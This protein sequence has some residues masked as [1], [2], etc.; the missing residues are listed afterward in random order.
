IMVLNM[1]GVSILADYFVIMHGNSERQVGAIADGILDAAEK[2]NIP[3]KRIEGQKGGDWLLIDL[4]D[5]IVHVFQHETRN[6]YNLEKLW[7]DAEDVAV[8]Q[9][10]TE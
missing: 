4:N 9:W 10:V 1:Q 3:V 6:F 5:V 8:S 2:Q 7:A